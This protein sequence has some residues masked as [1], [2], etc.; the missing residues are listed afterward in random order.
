MPNW[1]KPKTFNSFPT[2]VA[3]ALEENLWAHYNFDLSLNMCAG[4]KQNDLGSLFREKG[5]AGT[6]DVDPT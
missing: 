4:I 3:V 5:D 6:F 2:W 1:F